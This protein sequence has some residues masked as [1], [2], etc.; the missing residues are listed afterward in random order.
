M[1]TFLSGNILRTQ[2][3]KLV[4][5]KSMTQMCEDLSSITVCHLDPLV[6]DLLENKTDANTLAFAVTQGSASVSYCRSNKGQILCT[7]LRIFDL[8]SQIRFKPFP[9]FLELKNKLFLSS[10]LVFSSLL[11]RFVNT[12]RNMKP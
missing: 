12:L 8:S 4:Y 3:V 10:L 1:L 2:T 7:E 5:L 9:G 11:V 6:I